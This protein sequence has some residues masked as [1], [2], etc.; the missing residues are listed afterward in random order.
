ME[1]FFLLEGI[2]GALGLLTAAIGI[3]MGIFFSFLIKKSGNRSKGT[4]IGF[5]GG[6]MLA[7]VCFD[8]LPEAFEIGSIYISIIG[9]LLGLTLSV[10]LDGTLAHNSK[11]ST[12]DNKTRFFKAAIL[13]AIGIGIHN[14]P[15]GVAL[16]SLLATNTVK[17]LHLGVALIIHGIPEGLAIG[18]FLRE[19]NVKT[20]LTII[21]AM[22]TSIPMGLGSALG[23]MVSK[24]SEGM[25]CISLTFAAGMILYIIYRETLPSARDTWKGRL[26]TIGNVLGMV[27]GMLIVACT[28]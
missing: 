14:I 2:I 26:S 6:L 16:G 5:V 23:G 20:I 21:I 24:I 18:I 7:I 12:K 17:G 9:I 27:A 1:S 15:S 8:L 13:M 25:V 19:G 28:H 3:F 11:L 22:L 4:I 10:F